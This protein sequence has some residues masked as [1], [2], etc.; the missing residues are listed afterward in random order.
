VFGKHKAELRGQA[1]AVVTKATK[2]GGQVYAGANPLQGQWKYY[3]E[4]ELRVD[5]Q[6]GSSA[7]I[8]RRVGSRIRNAGVDFHVGDVV[9][10]RYDPD[11]RSKIEIDVEAY[12]DDIREKVAGI[13]D[14]AMYNGN[15]ALKKAAVLRDIAARTSPPTDEELQEAHA[16]KQATRDIETRAF[17]AK[18]TGASPSDETRLD[19]EWLHA[20]A[21]CEVVDAEFRALQALRPDWSPAAPQLV[22]QDTLAD[23]SATVG[24]LRAGTADLTETLA[25]IKSARAAGDLAEVDRLKAEFKRRSAASAPSSGQP[26]AGPA[27]SAAASDPLDRL[28]KLGELH[29][30]GV[31]TDT[32][33]AAEKAKILG[34]P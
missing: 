20:V 13:D 21:D 18:G 23:I 2:R 17:M 30:H 32:E 27:A 31:L 6:D 29:A 10:V 14:V 1:Q 26:V 9:S 24:R 5:F 16:R 19:T 33:F 34:E 12:K 25:A 11:D 28:Q 7:E 22:G 15:A 8:S 4:L 3:W